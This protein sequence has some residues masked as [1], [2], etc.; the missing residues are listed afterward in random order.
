MRTLFIADTVP[1][2]LNSGS[3]QRD[4][5]IL[6]ALARIS[7]VTLVSFL[8]VGDDRADLERLRH[9]FKDSYMLACGSAGSGLAQRVKHLVH[10][11]D[12]TQPAL[13]RWYYSEEAARLLG[14]LCARSYDLIW[15][16]KLFALLLLP[17]DADERRVFDLHDIESRRMFHRLKNVTPFHGKPL[18][19]LEYRKLLRFERRLARLPYELTVC[20][21]ADKE[22]L[23][24]G[25]QITVIPNG[26]DMPAGSYSRAL[27]KQPPIFL[28]VGTMSYAPNAD[29]A[30]FFARSILPRIQKEIPE[31]QFQIAGRDPGPRV[32]RLHD[33]R[34]ILVTGEVPD[35]GPY[36]AGA[37]AG[38]APIR[39]GGGTRIKILE[40]MS[41]GRP[42]VST[43]VGAEGIEGTDG[44]HF[45]LADE[46]AEFAAACVRLARDNAQWERIAE[47]GHLLVRERYE[48]RQI[49]REVERLAATPRAKDVHA[50]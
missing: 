27:V 22:A 39:F 35:V 24:G 16:E 41:Y 21:Q 46:P 18:E 19:W 8:Q 13:F 30:E 45:L 33:G 38:V 9:L 10:S 4:Y 37:T 25:P 3:K 1:Y 32:A 5:H 49:E 11:L 42:V 6:A 15:A 20:S 29:A 50:V 40:A 28:F 26:V 48:W 12:P 17:K 2:P 44:E 31:A 14:R 47:R 23:G 43:H 36:W 7:E 34:S